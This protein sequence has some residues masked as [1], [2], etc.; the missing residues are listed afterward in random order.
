MVRGELRFQ[1]C[2]VALDSVEFSDRVFGE[3]LASNF[4]DI[5]TQMAQDLIMPR[6]Y[7]AGLTKLVLE[8]FELQPDNTI[9][10]GLIPIFP[11]SHASQKR[12]EVNSP[13]PFGLYKLTALLVK[14]EF[15]DPDSILGRIEGV[16][17][18]ICRG[19]ELRTHIYA[20]LLARD[21]EA[22]E[23][24]KVFSSKQLDE[25]N[26][27]GRINL[28]AT[29]KDLMDDDKQGDMTIELFVAF[30][31]ETNAIAERSSE[32][33]SSQTLGLLAGFLLIDDW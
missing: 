22:F 28:A 6:E 26:K 10:L 2:K 24:Y 13:V 16:K 14:E 23:H 7:Q 27:N 31:M 17:F 1:K 9:F 29:G 5:I 25:S 15:I 30:D 18:L 4:A 11:K 33:E 21:D 8:F 20:H 3:E 32:L 12:I 19:C